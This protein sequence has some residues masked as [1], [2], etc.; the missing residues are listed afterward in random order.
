MVGFVDGAFIVTTATVTDAPR[1]PWRGALVDTSRH[2]QPLPALYA[3]VDALAYSKMNVLHW[4][5]TDDQA[6]PFV[7]AAFPALSGEG[8]YAAPATSHTYSPA[9]VAAVIAFAKDRG[10][11]VVPEFDTPG[12]SQSWGLGQPGLLT[13]CY[14]ATGPDGTYGPIDPTVNSTWAFLEALF[15]EVAGVFPDAFFHVGGDGERGWV[16]RWGTAL[17]RSGVPH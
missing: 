10:V 12:H 3:F 13:A 8:A 6:F 2:F 9:D 16:G 7:S 17:P 1:F 4:H 5:I 11:R 15:A 14:N